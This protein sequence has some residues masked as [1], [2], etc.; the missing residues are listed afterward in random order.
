MKLKKRTRLVPPS[1]QDILSVFFL[2]GVIACIARSL[3]S[4]PQ[5]L[6]VGVCIHVGV[7]VV[8]VLYVV[9]CQG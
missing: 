5:F 6:S 4:P 8:V 1:E 7:R 9:L 2:G 3:A